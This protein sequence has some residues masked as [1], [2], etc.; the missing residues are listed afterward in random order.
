MFYKL[1]HYSFLSNNNYTHQSIKNL[2]FPSQKMNVF[3]HTL[4]KHTLFC[5][6]F[7]F[8]FYIYLIYILYNIYT[9]YISE[10]S[11][12]QLIV[13]V[14]YVWIGSELYHRNKINVYKDIITKTL[15]PFVYLKWQLNLINHIEIHIVVAVFTLSFPFRSQSVSVS[16]ANIAIKTKPF[17]WI[18]FSVR[19]GFVWVWMGLYGFVWVVWV[20]QYYD[21]LIIN[22]FNNK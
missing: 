2:G 10:P 22:D 12:N 4:L 11:H 17:N 3:S 20:E 16:E 9:V 7:I 13:F 1:R 6:I 18:V 8:C 5:I 15:R 21:S 19:N 14:M